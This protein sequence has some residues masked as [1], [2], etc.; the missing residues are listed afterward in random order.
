MKFYNSMGPNPHMVRM[1]AAEKGI[2][3]QKEDVDLRAG[4]NRK[5]PY[6]SRNPHGQLPALE[7]DN[8]ITISRGRADLRISRGEAS[9]ARR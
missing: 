7:L 8:G 6:L 4:D 2:E 1:F 3:L 9:D 5:E